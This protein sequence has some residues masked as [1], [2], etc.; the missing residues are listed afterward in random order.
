MKKS[1]PFNVLSNQTCTF[2]FYGRRVCN[3]KLKRRLVEEKPSTTLCHKHFKML[4]GMGISTNNIK[5]GI[6]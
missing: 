1:Y 4:K 2:V 5:K 3:K 6:Y